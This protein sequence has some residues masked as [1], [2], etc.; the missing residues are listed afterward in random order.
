MSHWRTISKLIVEIQIAPTAK[1]WRIKTNAETTEPIPI[2]SLDISHCKIGNGGTY[3]GTVS[4][5]RIFNKNSE[6][7]EWE[8]GKLPIPPNI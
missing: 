3:K 5:K 7:E 2:E 6:F 8:W 1:C 4:L